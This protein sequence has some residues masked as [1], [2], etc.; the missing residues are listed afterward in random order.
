M[1]SVKDG[2]SIVVAFAVHFLCVS[3]TSVLFPK[4][5]LSRLI[6]PAVDGMG[7]IYLLVVITRSSGHH[8]LAHR[9][10]AAWRNRGRCG[11]R[12]P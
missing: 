12:G 3:F 2:S 8:R 6:V 10:P 11:C 7:D 5:H 9:T 4:Y 1:F